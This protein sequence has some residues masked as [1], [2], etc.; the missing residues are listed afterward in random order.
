MNS[1]KSFAIV[2]T[3]NFGVGVHNKPNFN[4]S[5][6]YSVKDWTDKLLT[7]VACNCTNGISLV[8]S[9]GTHFLNFCC[10]SFWL[11]FVIFLCL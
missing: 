2:F 9:T 10:F 1:N 6:C 3:S 7:F 4:N 8:D 11:N 5:V